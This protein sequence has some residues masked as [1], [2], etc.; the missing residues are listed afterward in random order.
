MSSSAQDTGWFKSSYS[1]I[2]SNA[3][4]ECRFVAGE[5]VGLRD[6]KNPGGDALWVAPAAWQSFV[7]RIKTGG[8]DPR[9]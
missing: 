3:C 8:F 9:G 5:C 1:E 6:S 7:A 2:S 4:V